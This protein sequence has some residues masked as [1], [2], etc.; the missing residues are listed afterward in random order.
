MKGKM[1]KYWICQ[2]GGWSTYIIVYTFLLPDP[3]HQR[4]TLFF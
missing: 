2:I 3:T 4:A 1:S